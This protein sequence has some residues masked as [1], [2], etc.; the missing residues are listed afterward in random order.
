MQKGIACFILSVST[1]LNTD[2][3]QGVKIVILKC[4]RGSSFKKKFNTNLG[5]SV[6]SKPKSDLH[7]ATTGCRLGATT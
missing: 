3:T 7:V 6:S 5:I 2:Y 4:S 1:A